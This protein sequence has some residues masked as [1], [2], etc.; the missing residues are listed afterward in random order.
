[1]TNQSVLEKLKKDYLDYVLSWVEPNRLKLVKVEFCASRIMA[2]IASA[3]VFRKSGPA[4][5]KVK[6]DADGDRVFFKDEHGRKIPAYFITALLAKIIKQKYPK[7]KIAHDSRLVWAIQEAAQNTC[8]CQAGWS[9]FLKFMHKNKILFGGEASGHYYF[10][11]F[12]SKIKRFSSREATRGSYYFNRDFILNDGLIPVV[13]IA[14]HIAKTKK[15]LSELISPYQ[16]KY[17]VSP[18]I[19]FKKKIDSKKIEKDYQDAQISYSDGLSVEYPDWRFNLR[20]SR[21][22]NLW[23]LNLEARDKKILAQKQ[24]ELYEKI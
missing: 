19:N 16:A 11:S 7:A 9:N 14:E 21:T 2:D 18:E 4:D 23:R 17:F 3:L 6:W 13:L 20:P 15:T 24:K 10:A 12:A 5:F 22:E 1:M 8:V